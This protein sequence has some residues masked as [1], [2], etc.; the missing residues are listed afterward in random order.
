MRPDFYLYS[1]GSSITEAIKD[2][3]VRLSVTD[4][5]GFESDELKLVLSNHNGL[6]AYPVHGAELTL[7]LGYKNNL[8]RMGRYTVNEVEL[9]GPPD[10]ITIRAKATDMGGTLKQ[11]RSQAWSSNTISD[12]V[13]IVAGRHQLK[14]KVSPSLAGVTISYIE[15]TDESDL[16]FLTR[17]AESHDAICKPANGCLIFLEKGSGKSVTGKSLASYEVYRKQITDYRLTRPDRVSYQKVTAKYT[18]YDNGQQR[19]LSVGTGEPEYLLSDLFQNSDD[20][21]DAV[22]AKFR[23]LQRSGASL[24]ITM[25]GNPSISAETSIVCSG[26][27]DGINGAWIVT[28]VEHRLDG[29]G[30]TIA[31]EAGNLE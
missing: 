9:S 27:P 26:F 1:N 2:H 8:T 13:R 18:D 14:P 24:E 16:H 28:R 10:T 30:L 25:P 20:A 11:K 19:K 17:I 22:K 3:F 6:L 21:Q 4:E 12:I 23:A 31:I 7:D 15:Q 5:T 29:N